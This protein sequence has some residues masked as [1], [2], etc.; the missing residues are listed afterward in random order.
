MKKVIVDNKLQDD[1]IFKVLETAIK[2]GEVINFNDKLYKRVRA[3]K[4]TN[5]KKFIEVEKIEPDILVEK[6]KDEI[7]RKYIC[8]SSE[9]GATN[10]IKKYSS[11]KRALKWLLSLDGFVIYD[12]KN[13]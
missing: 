11:D 8:F 1:V 6:N 3:T 9:V 13:E 12:W 7:N 10:Y 2:Y 4:N 5:H